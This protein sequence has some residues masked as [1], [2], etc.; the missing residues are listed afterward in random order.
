LFFSDFHM[1]KNQVTREALGE[2]RIIHDEHAYDAIHKVITEN[3]RV[4]FI[5]TVQPGISL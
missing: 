1:C 4:V 2:N 5:F 3:R